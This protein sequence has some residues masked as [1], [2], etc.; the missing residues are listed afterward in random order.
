MSKRKQPSSLESPAAER[1]G[2]EIPGW[3]SRIVGHAA[4]PPESLLANPLNHRR[5]PHQQRAALAAS[6]REVGFVRSVMVNRTTGHIVDG[7]ERVWQA[8]QAGT[9]T[10]D[11]EFVELSAGEE[12]LVLATLDRIGELAAVDAD[13]LETLLRDVQTADEH[14]AALLDQMAAQA[15]LVPEETP[16]ASAD[17]LPDLFQ[18][19]IECQTESQQRDLLQRF[20]EEG[21]T[22]RSLIA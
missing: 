7:H 6:I 4:V 5:H 19:L 16:P 2:G 18:I 12:R 20:Q 3:R 1:S 8:V 15:G 13:A 17:S 11:V 10:I 14:L 9:A 22:C 21:L